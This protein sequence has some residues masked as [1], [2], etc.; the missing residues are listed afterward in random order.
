MKL[1][2]LPIWLLSSSIFLRLLVPQATTAQVTA[3]TTLPDDSVVSCNQGTCEITG[4]TRPERDGNLFHSFEQFSVPTGGEAFFNNDPTVENIISRVTGSSVSDIDGLIRANGRANLFLIN[5]NGIIFGESASLNIGGSFIASTANSIQFADGTEFSTTPTQVEPLLTISTPIGLGFDH[6]PGRI[7]NRSIVSTDNDLIGL[8]VQP[9]Q[10]LALVGGDISIEGGFLT[11]EG[12]RIELGS[13]GGSTRVRLMPIN[14]GWTLDY[15]GIQSFR[16]IS[17]SLAALV[18]ST[19]DSSGDIQIQGRRITLIEGSQI[20]LEAQMGQAGDLTVRAS[21]SVELSGNSADAGLDFSIPTLLYNDV[22]GEATGERSRLTVETGRLIIENGAQILTRTFGA[23]QGVDLEISAFEIRLEGAFISEADHSSSALLS[24]VRPRATGDGGTLTIQAERLIIRD[25]AQVFTETR[26]A[27]DA[28]ALVVN[29]SE[30]VELSGT[31]L[32]T[33]DPSSLFADVGQVATAT[34]DGGALTITTGQLVIRNGA[35][36]ATVARN[37][38]QGGTLIINADSVRLSG[39]SPLA[40]FRRGSRSGIFVSAEPAFRDREGNL[41]ITTADAGELRITAEELIVEDGALISADNFGTGGGSEVTLNVEQ[42]I[43]QDGGQIGAGSF[44]E[45]NA[46]NNERGPG[47]TLIINASESVEVSGTGFIG[48][49]SVNSALLTRSEGT[50]DAGDLSIRTGSLNV[51]DGAEVTVSSFGSGAAGNL[52][53]TADI[54]RLDGGSLT[55]E[56]LVGE[57]GNIILQDLDLLLMQDQSQITAQAFGDADGGNVFIT[58]PDGFIVAAAGQDN[59]IIASADR[60]SG[61]VIEIEAQDILGIEE[62]QNTPERNDIDASSESGAPGTVMI[63]RLEIDPAQGITELPDTP[64]ASEPVQGCQVEGG[65]VTVEFFDTG[66]G[67]LPPTPYEP[68]SSDEILDD[69]RL[70]SQNVVPPEESIA[71]PESSA[72]SDEPIVEAEGWIVNDRGEIVLLAEAP[73]P[74]QGCQLR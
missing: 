57:G 59:N 9:D 25:G 5:P 38:G 36:I 50:G 6:T 65:E 56:I 19:G 17:L 35:Q 67:G 52:T 27:G 26:G 21:E 74:F 3:D 15:E 12:G 22:S 44:L 72:P 14:Q 68:L 16:D 49:E 42:L 24:E 8:R 66:R 45:R 54:I 4:G 53:I 60:G 71:P 13:V 39:A 20:F 40:G 10:T 32:G 64:I 31:I 33:D 63:T 23:G 58:A 29:A 1:P 73:T 11:T 62:R 55:A 48:S 34:G 37:Q 43:V 70:P 69:V 51:R 46:V 2:P 18:A 61:G 41:I 7:I 30:S 47:G 28:G